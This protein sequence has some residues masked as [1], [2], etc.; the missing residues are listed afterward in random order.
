MNFAKNSVVRNWIESWKV[1]WLQKWYPLV[2]GIIDL[3]FL[4]AFGF[5]TGPVFDALSRHI[6]IIGSLVSG[7]LQTPAGRA[8]PA[9][10][11]VLFQEPAR[12]FTM[13]FLGLLAVLGVVVFVLYCLFQGLNWYLAKTLIGK[14][15]KWRTFLLR[16]TKINVLWFLLYAIWYVVDA[17]FD[18]RRLA[19]EKATGQTASGAGIALLAV[20]A[21]M[22]YFALVS[23]PLMSVRAGFVL[24]IRRFAVLVPAFVL[25]AVQFL[26][27]NRLLAWLAPISRTTVFVLGAIFLF[28]LFAWTRV[29]VLK[30]VGGEQEWCLSTH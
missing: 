13:Q 10:M 21:I 18:L 7:A 19:I 4:V 1:L 17:V 11:G 28:V 14:P 15:G 20:I 23:Y 9:V 22:I 5:F 26:A 3:F 29:F 25:I 2:S 8:R 16:F 24:G 6:I 27:A 12:Q 30:I